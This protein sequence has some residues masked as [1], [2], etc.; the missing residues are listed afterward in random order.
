M[1][2][3]RHCEY[4]R[5]LP[6]GFLVFYLQQLGIRQ[7]RAD[8]CLSPPV[9]LLERHWRSQGWW[10]SEPVVNPVQTSEAGPCL[11][12]CA[13][14]PLSDFVCFGTIL[15]LYVVPQQGTESLGIHA[16]VVLFSLRIV[17]PYEYPVAFACLVLGI[18]PISPT[19]P[20]V[21]FQQIL[22]GYER[23]QTYIAITI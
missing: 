11:E 7:G 16:T 10:D 5:V 4:P 2:R 8:L 3:V 22:V 17:L 18:F 19:G 23:N 21:E 14:A 13:T 12:T 6:S 1:P 9:G 20:D 15:G